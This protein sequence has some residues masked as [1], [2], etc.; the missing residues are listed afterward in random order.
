MIRINIKHDED[1]DINITATQWKR[2]R[3]GTHIQEAMPNLD[4]D[5]REF[6][7]SGI[8]PEEWDELFGGIEE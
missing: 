6:L 4:A 2:W 7:I 3:Q 5:E 1:L 8:A